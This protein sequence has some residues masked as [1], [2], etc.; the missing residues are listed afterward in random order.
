MGHST[1]YNNC[2][3]EIFKLN[4]TILRRLANIS[5][6]FLTI[7]ITYNSNTELPVNVII[8]RLMFNITKI[9]KRITILLINTTFYYES[10]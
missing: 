2:F 8:K 6:N 7:Q 9:L 4:E 3:C 10:P 5:T 1:N